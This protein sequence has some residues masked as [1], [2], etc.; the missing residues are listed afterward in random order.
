MFRDDQSIKL[1]VHS[2]LQTTVTYVIII[3]ISYIL[4]IQVIFTLLEVM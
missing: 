3:N 2:A 4:C 1:N